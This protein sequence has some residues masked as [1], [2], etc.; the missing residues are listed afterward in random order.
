MAEDRIVIRDLLVR[1]VIG[2]NEWERQVRQDILLNLVVFT[3]LR[4]A[5]ETDD[6]A[7]TVDYKKLT[8]KI[9]A[10]V[11]S[12]ARL[13]VEALAAD[14]ARLC[15]EQ[16]GVVRARV[17]VEKPGALRFAQSVGVEIERG[18]GDVNRD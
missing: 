8:K 2:V 4:R 16:P 14:V 9:I 17:R 1:G 12:T 11:E 6:I 10:H 13:T 15:L 3:D 18:V 5:G 7:D